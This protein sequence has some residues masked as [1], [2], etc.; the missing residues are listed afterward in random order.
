MAALIFGVHPIHVESVAWITERKD[1]LY[2]AFYMA[3]L[4][5]YLRYLEER[6]GLLALGNDDAGGLEHAGQADGLEP[7]A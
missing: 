1:V 6:R 4:L 7:A 5:S 2:A 3:A